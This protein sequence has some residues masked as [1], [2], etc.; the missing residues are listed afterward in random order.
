MEWG[1][2]KVGIGKVVEAGLVESL[3]H[4][5]LAPVLECPLDENKLGS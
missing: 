4:L 1:V 2:V 3:K 5:G